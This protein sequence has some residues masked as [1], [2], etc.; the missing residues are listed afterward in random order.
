VIQEFVNAAF[1]PQMDDYLALEGGVNLSL[2]LDGHG[3]SLSFLLLEIPLQ[4]PK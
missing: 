3:K 1:A 4:I 2:S